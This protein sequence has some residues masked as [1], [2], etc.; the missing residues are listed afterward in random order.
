VKPVAS[1]HVS[2][3]G[4]VNRA[5]TVGL[6]RPLRAFSACV[7]LLA[8][9]AGCSAVNPHYNPAKPH[10]TPQG[11][12]NNYVDTVTKGF[13]ELLRWQ[14]ERREQG[15]PRS[16]AQATPRQQPDLAAIKAYPASTG[17]LSKRAAPPHITWIGHA[18]MLVQA[19]GLNTLVDPIFSERASPVH[20]AGPRR[21]QAPGLA[22]DDLPRIDVVLISHSHY[23][24]LDKA[25][26]LEIAR[27]SDA[28]GRPALFVVPLGLKSWFTN[29]GISHVAELDWWDKQV[30]GAV[31]FYLTPVQHWS[32]RSFGDRSE[33]LWGGYAVFAPDL[34]W[35]YSGDTGYSKDFADTARHFST[36]PDAGNAGGFDLAL[37][38]VGAYEPRWFM[39]QQ[40][41]NPM[42]A[43]QIHRDIRSRRSVGVHWGTFELTDE[44]L[45]E[46][47]RGLQAA[48]GAT[49]LP[50]GEFTVMAIGQ[51][52]ALPPRLQP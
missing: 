27:R 47:P 34:H 39:K 20:F 48:T 42:E 11:F 36:R 14:L 9:V 21:A 12:K 29:L 10:H 22:L 25:S 41:V 18:S 15:L 35:Y 44:P 19:G 28:A 50:A 31:E 37:I 26:V 30:Y 46:P 49:G 23:D 24:H 8:C 40:H 13:S 38:A 33:T 16:A 1:G 52:L 6:L 51:T 32:A 4:A 7:T 43:V 17:V 45:D 3:H 2:S 5:G